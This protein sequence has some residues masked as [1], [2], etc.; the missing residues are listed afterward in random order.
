MRSFSPSFVLVGGSLADRVGRRRI[1]SIGDPRLRSLLARVRPRARRRRPSIAARAAQGLGAALLVPASLAMLGAGFSPADARPRRRDLVFSDGDLRGDRSLPRRMARPGG[2]L[3][4]GLL[5]QPPGRGGRARDRDPEGAREPESVG[6]PPGFRRSGARDRA[7]SGALVFGLIE[8][9]SARRA[10]TP[11]CSRRYSA[12]RPLSPSSSPSSGT[13]AMPMVP[14]A[15][16]RVRSFAAANLLTFF[17]YAALSA[18]LL[19]PAVRP[20]PG[21]RILAGRGGSGAP[22]ARARDVSAVALVRSARGPLRRRASRSRSA[23]PSRPPGFSCWRSSRDRDLTFG[24]SCRRS[25]CSVSAWR[26]RWR[27]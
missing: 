26:S 16:F 14:T 23:R 15:L 5:P 21:P 22:P 24:F 17:L 20:D 6:R 9:P 7:A 12:A 1:F 25:P 19:L 3:A 13:G 11:A 18:A 4:R 2:F 8:A 27:P 10:A